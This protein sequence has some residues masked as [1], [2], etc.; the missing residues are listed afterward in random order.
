MVLEL[1]T[2]GELFDRIV[3]KEQYSEK[4][5]CEV[6]TPIVDAIA[7]CHDLGIAHRDLKVHYKNVTKNPI[8]TFF[9]LKKA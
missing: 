4:E 7:Y 9:L 5:A 2:G 3:E 8:F 6:I 1:M